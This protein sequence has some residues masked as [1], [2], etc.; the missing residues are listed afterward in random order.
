MF[1]LSFKNHKDDIYCLRR[2]EG[3]LT[4]ASE[5]SSFKPFQNI[6]VLIYEDVL[7]FYCVGIIFN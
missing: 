5:I 4:F 6:Q 3:Y 1:C 2:S 7:L